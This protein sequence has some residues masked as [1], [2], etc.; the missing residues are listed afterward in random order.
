[1][2]CLLIH[3]LLV[4]SLGGILLFDYLLTRFSGVICYCLEDFS[5]H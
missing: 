2:M 4:K 3:I 5:C 1:M